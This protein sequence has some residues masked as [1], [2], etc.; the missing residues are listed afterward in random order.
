MDLHHFTA[1]LRR[2]DTATLRAAVRRWKAA[3]D[4]TTAG[5]V[6]RRLLHTELTGTPW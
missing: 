5:T 4:P 3:A 1:A 2:A 6:E